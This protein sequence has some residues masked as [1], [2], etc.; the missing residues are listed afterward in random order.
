M[1]T[2][3]LN[4]SVPAEANF[5]SGLIRFAKRVVNAVVASRIRNAEHELRRYDVFA[6]D[7]ALKHGHPPMLLNRDDLVPFKL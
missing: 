5:S 2:A 7:L 4:R 6:R 1:T 3:V